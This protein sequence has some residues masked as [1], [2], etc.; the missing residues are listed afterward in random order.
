MKIF[1][2]KLLLLTA[3]SLLFIGAKEV[4]PD[5]KVK[6]SGLVCDA[7]GIGI[8]KWLKKNLSIKDVRLNTK[9]GLT[10]IYLKNK[11]NITDK[12]VNTAMRKAG[13]EATKITRKE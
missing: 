11:K 10:L 7:C 4:A 1:A 13:Y 5:I 6:T 3:S 2:L 9:E 12:E 8:K